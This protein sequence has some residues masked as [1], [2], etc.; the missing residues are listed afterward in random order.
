MFNS[1]MFEDK[2]LVCLAKSSQYVLDNDITR[3]SFHTFSDLQGYSYR[4][5]P[6]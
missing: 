2:L 1:D 3:S 5:A 6:L 4:E